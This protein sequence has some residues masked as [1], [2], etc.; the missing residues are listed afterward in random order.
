[1]SVLKPNLDRVCSLGDQCPLVGLYK[2]RR[3]ALLSAHISGQDAQHLNIGHDGSYLY[4]DD[5]LFLLTATS[6][7]PDIVE[8]EGRGIST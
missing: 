2:A 7:H 8:L 5:W 3:P 6:V 4:L 1:M